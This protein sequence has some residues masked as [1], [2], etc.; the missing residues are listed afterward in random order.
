M[1]FPVNSGNQRK[2]NANS[3]ARR[4]RS[5]FVAALDRL[6]EE[7]A[8]LELLLGVPTRTLQRWR[9]GAKPGP[10]AEAFVRAMELAGWVLDLGALSRGVPELNADVAARHAAEVDAARAHTPEAPSC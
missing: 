5:S 6:E 2:P 4:R 1:G 10:I 7:G 9:A 8:G 3:K